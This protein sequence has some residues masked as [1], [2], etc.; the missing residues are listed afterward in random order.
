MSTPRDKVEALI[1]M[2]N[3]LADMIEADIA[4]LRTR[5]PAQLARTEA[6]REMAMLQYSRAVAEFR[7]AGTA[8]LLQ[9]DLKTRLNA[10][11]RRVVSATRE[12]NLMLAR[13]RHVTEGLIRSVANVVIDR[14]T[15]AVYSKSGAM[16]RNAAYSRGA[17]MT[18]NQAV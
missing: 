7:N 12:Q 17:A 16:A 1:G 4:I 14:E 15:P 18:F 3:R 11:T 2:S 13:F 9:A 8:K 6:D 10:A 5:R